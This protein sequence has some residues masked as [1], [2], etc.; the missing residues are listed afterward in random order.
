MYRQDPASK[1]EDFVMLARLRVPALTC[2]IGVSTAAVVLL[3]LAAPAQAATHRQIIRGPA[4]P[5]AGASSVTNSRFFAGYVATVPVGSATSVTASFTVPRLSCPPPN[6]G[7]FA[8][9]GEDVNRNLLFTGALVAIKC[10]FGKAV[11]FPALV[12]NNVGT[13]YRSSPFAKGDVINLSASVTTTGTTVQVTDVTKNVS[14]STTINGAG[15]SANAAW[16]GDDPWFSST[17]RLGVPNFGKLKFTNC[18]IDGT[19]CRPGAL[20]NSSE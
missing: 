13:S 8:G 1:W 2:T 20:S 17:G 19:P 12:I 5:R 18:L 11:Y 7:T 6:L 16:I 9:A 4:I 3:A 10:E 14:V 15:A